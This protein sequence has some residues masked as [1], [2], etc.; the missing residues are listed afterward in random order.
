[1]SLYDDI[2]TA[3]WAYPTRTVDGQGIPASNG[4]PLDNI[5]YAIWTNTTRTLTG[6]GPTAY[7]LS[8]DRSVLRG[9]FSRIFGRV[10]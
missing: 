9:V 5:R 2:A 3:V 1:M 4:S 6:G 8:L 7:L 10:N